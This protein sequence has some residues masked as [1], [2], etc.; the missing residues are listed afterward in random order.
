MKQ[1]KEEKEKLLSLFPDKSFVLEI[2]NGYCSD[3]C[4]KHLPWFTVTTK[5]GPITI[6]WRKR[7]ISIDWKQTVRTKT[8]NELFAK[9]DVTKEYK[10]IHAWSYEDAKRYVNAIINSVE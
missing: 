8:S 10:L 1:A 2:P 9:E 6:G 7:V 3:W 5:V 4:C